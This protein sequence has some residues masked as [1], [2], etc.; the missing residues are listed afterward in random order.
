M[1]TSGDIKRETGSTTLAAGDQAISTNY[2]KNIIVR[3]KL[4]VNTG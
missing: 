2:F 3:K 1:D 4:A